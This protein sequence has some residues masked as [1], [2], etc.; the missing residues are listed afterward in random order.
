MGVC[1]SLSLWDTAGQEG[2]T[3]LRSLSYPE[4]DVFVVCFSTV[5]CASFENV[6]EKWIPE[7]KHYCPDVP[8]L[9]VGTKADLRTEEFVSQQPNEAITTEMGKAMA[10]NLNMEAY[11]ECSAKKMDGLDNVFAEA[12]RIYVRK[13]RQEEEQKRLERAKKWKCILL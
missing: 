11:L 1:F 12:V 6:R 7:V 8:C 3:R 9:L 4:T 13:R 10:Y 2:Y 5:A